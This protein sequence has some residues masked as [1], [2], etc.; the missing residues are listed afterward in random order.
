MIVWGESCLGKRH[1]DCIGFVNYC[2]GK[3]WWR[4]EKFAVDINALFDSPTTY[5]FVIVN[6]PTDILNADLVTHRNKKG[7]GWQHIGMVYLDESKQAKVVQASESYEGVTKGQVYE[8]GEWGR[9]IRLLDDMIRVPA[10][11]KY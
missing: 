2:I 8:A 3:V 5:G 11:P 1:F 4:T 10:S 6:D 7:T 9:R